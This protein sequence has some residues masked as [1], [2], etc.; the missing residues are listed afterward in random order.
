MTGAEDLHRKLLQERMACSVEPLRRMLMDHPMYGRLDTL[1]SL[2]VFMEAHVFAVWDFMSLVKCLQQRV[3]CV[4]T[5]W[6]PPLDCTSARLINEIVLCEES[7]CASDGRHG[8]HFDFYL[9]AMDE[10]RA[11]TRPMREFIMALRQGQPVAA[12]IGHTGVTSSTKAFVMNTMATLERGTHEVAASFLL[13]R[14]SVIPVMFEQVLKVTGTMRVPMLNWYLARHIEVD[15]EEHG[16]AG[17]QLLERLC[18]SDPR[19]W[20]EAEASARRALHARRALWDGVC[21]AMDFERTS[22]VG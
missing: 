8:S 20:R 9:E 4:R 16:P 12:A 15:G 10:V 11:D 19:L 7:D 14:E 13:G 17:W 1:S 21:E 22:A 18:G 5:P 2:R 6:L 3:T